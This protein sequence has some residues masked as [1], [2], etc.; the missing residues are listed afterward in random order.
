MVDTPSSNM[1]HQVNNLKPFCVLTSSTIFHY[2]PCLI[3]ITD[4]RAKQAAGS[5]LRRH[6]ADGGGEWAFCAFMVR[7]GARRKRDRPRRAL[8]PLRAARVD[9]IDALLG[10]LAVLGRPL[11]GLRE[12]EVGDRAETHRMR[13]TAEHV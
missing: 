1:Q 11:P 10:E 13:N 7:F 4:C 2:N 9:R 8:G 3:C 6:L 12:T 5:A